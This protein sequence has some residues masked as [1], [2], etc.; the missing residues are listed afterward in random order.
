MCRFDLK[1][2]QVL[3]S[4]VFKDILA[5]CTREE[6]VAEDIFNDHLLALEKCPMYLEI[7]MDSRL[8]WKI[9]ID[10]AGKK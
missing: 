5:E 9:Q 7:T 8:T 4:L 6:S 2:L 10:K 3:Y 1:P